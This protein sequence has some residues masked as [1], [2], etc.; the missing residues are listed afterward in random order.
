MRK[1]ILAA[2][3]GVLAVFLA[4]GATGPAHPQTPSC[5]EGLERYVEHRLFFGRSRQGVEVV[6]DAAWHAFLADEITTRFPDGLTVLDA[7]GQWRD[8]SGTVTRERAKL[9][10]ILAV[11]GDDSLRRTEEIA[12]QFKRMFDQESVL[13]VS[14]EVCASFQ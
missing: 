8:S 12:G 14:G 11:P 9:V 4:G 7:A 5:P 3:I 6:S 13:R 1:Q 2:S 10:V